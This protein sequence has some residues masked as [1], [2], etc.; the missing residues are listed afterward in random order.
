M[1][2]RYFL[3]FSMGVLTLAAGPA[4]GQVPPTPPN[5][6][7]P[8]LAAPVPLG[9]QRG[10]KLDLVLAGSNLTEPT[11]L[12][13]SFPAKVTIPTDNNN[14]KDAAKLRVQ[15]EIP[16]DAPLGFHAI[17]LATSRGLSNFR[18]FCID[19]LPQVVE[20]E[21]NRNKATPQSVA[22]PSVVVGR[23]DAEKSSYY[24]ISVKA[25]QRVSFEVLGRRLGSAFDPEI[26]VLHPK[27]GREL[28]YS[29]DS[30]GLQ[31]DA[32]L[33]YTFKDAGDYIL[34]IRDVAYKGG[35][36][37]WYRLRIGDFP[38]ATTPIPMAIKR[39]AKASVQFAGP[40]VE[41]VAAVE[42]TAPT[43]PAA[44][45]IWVAPKGANGL[46]GWPVELLLSDFEEAVEQEPNNEIAKANRVAVPGGITGRFAE[47]ND[48]D[49]YVFMAKKGQRLILDGITSEMHSP[50]LLYMVLKDAKG[51][52]LAKSNPQANPPADQRID[53]T[54]PADGDYYLEVQHLNYV[55]GP[56]ESYRVTV[57]PYEPGFDLALGIDRFDAAQGGSLSIPLFVTRRDYTGPIDVSVTGL[58]GLTGQATIPGAPTPPP[59]PNQPAGVLHVKVAPETAMGPHTFVIQ[60][61]AT[62]NN[63]T[64][65]AY[66]NQHMAIRATLGNLPFPPQ[67]LFH[68]IGLAVTE[69][70][71]FTLAVKFERPETLRGA[72]IN[73]TITATRAADFTEEI[74]LTAGGLPPNVAPMLKNIAKGQNEVQV[75]LT[76]AANAPLGTFPI[77]FTG[78]TKFQSK[79][80][81]V[82]AEPASLAVVLPF[83]L[84]VEPVPLKLPQ[85][86]KSKLKIT[87]TR[88]AGYQ[89]PIN[90][91]LR[92]LPANVTAP[93]AAIE[94]AQTAVEVEI[95]A[96]GTAAVADK[97]D[98]NVL[99]TATTAA[100]QQNA[101][102][103]FTVSVQPAAPSPAT[104]ELKAEGTPLKI[105]QGGKAK[106]KV[107]VARK[108]YQGPI[109]IELKNLPANV[110]AAKA[111]IAKDQASAEIEVSAADAAVAGDKADVHLSGVGDTPADK[112]VNSPNFTLSVQKK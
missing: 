112:P 82:A 52:E 29:N 66:A 37:Y 36:D 58:A 20:V 23:I 65:T 89:G 44:R 49:Y 15:L 50:A 46:H 31:T 93:K 45:S 33:T 85:G 27:T 84:K 8:V 38:C 69:K 21:T 96:A 7:A 62:I 104:F 72:A 51:A 57:T 74:A 34:E 26:R 109:T 100:N 70:A 63:K 13:T 83:D 105:T 107:T 6:Q 1:K 41:G 101:S 91:E 9:M 39:G 17:R 97:A 76:P 64:I 94:M 28:T 110:T 102:P 68:P 88:K 5:P 60:A 10:T 79:D 48:L 61:K 19:D 53:F 67:Y 16:A 90:V 71:P 55:G 108:G 86:G 98:V 12:W 18:L 81:T 42:V 14:G 24:Q 103:N 25:G 78:K 32:R 95:S 47:K 2:S 80:F 59:P 75:Q 106:L 30:P 92:N 111:T 40:N 54:P 99:G 43:D 11:G 77:T 22:V 4:F 87:A 56:S 35:P 73:A 3:G